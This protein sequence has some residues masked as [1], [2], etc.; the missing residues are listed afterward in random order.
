MAIKNVVLEDDITGKYNWL[1]MT[2][3]AGEDIYLNLA[4]IN[5]I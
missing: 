2:R 3:K 5:F 1:L 4:V